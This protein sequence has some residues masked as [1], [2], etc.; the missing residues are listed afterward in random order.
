[1][2]VEKRETKKIL[3]HLVRLKDLEKIFIT[4]NDAQLKMIANNKKIKF[5][6]LMN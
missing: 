1:M 2:N 3:N 5:L 4:S 6:V